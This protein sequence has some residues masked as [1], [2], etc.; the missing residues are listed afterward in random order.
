MIQGM[1]VPLFFSMTLWAVILHDVTYLKKK[2]KKV[3]SGKKTSDVLIEL[4]YSMKACKT[5]PS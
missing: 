1:T 2:K 4:M 5:L 3:M